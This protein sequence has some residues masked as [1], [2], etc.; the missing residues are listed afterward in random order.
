MQATAITSVP[1]LCALWTRL[2]RHCRSVLG[3][4]MTAV[5][6][7]ASTLLPGMQEADKCSISLQISVLLSGRSR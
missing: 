4:L 5:S 2:T 3:S 6:A 7:E 1:G